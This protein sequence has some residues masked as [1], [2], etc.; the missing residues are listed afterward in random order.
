[1]EKTYRTSDLY[2]AA[3]LRTEELQLVDIEV[4]ERGQ[5]VF[6]FDDAPKRHKLVTDFF[7]GRLIQNTRKYVDNWLSLKKLVVARVRK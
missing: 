3:A 1:M 5:G 6:V 4:D 7:S 2:L